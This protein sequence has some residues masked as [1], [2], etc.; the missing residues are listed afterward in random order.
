MRPNNVS[1][2]ESGSVSVSLTPP[3]K[4]E[5]HNLCLNKYI[6]LFVSDLHANGTYRL[7]LDC[8]NAFGSTPTEVL[9]FRTSERKTRSRDHKLWRI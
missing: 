2:C 1:T 9:V 8:R 6:L 3:L 4:N 7:E 5:K